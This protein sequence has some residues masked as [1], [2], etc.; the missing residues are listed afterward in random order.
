[1]LPGIAQAHRRAA[2][3]SDTIVVGALAAEQ[4]ALERF[5]ALL[6]REQDELREPGADAVRSLAAAKQELL[7]DLS[8]LRDARPAW[9]AQPGPAVKA[10]LASLAA[11]AERARRMNDGNSRLHAMHAQACNARLRAL[12]LGVR[13]ADGL[14]TDRGNAQSLRTLGLGGSV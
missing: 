5:I 13:P 3:A 9:S 12:G 6:G 4:Q 8:R 10:A 14:Y 11:V 2:P 7:N 1:M